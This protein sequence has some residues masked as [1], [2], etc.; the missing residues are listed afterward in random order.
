[1]F[2]L[3]I[4]MNRGA[5]LS[6]SMPSDA[7]DVLGWFGVWG[8]SSDSVVRFVFGLPSVLVVSEAH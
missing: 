8:P 5:H 2:I 4:P 3:Q 6:L 7:W 1:M